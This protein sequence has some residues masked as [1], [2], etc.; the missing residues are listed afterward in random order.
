MMHL[1]KHLGVSSNLCPWHPYSETS[2]LVLGRQRRT[3]A[4]K[5]VHGCCVGW[6]APASALVLLLQPPGHVVGQGL[7]LEGVLMEVLPHCPAASLVMKTQLA[8]Y[9]SV[10]SHGGEG[11]GRGRA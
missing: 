4:V 8:K 9:Q 6:E 10:K 7:L 1:F 2:V 3:K 5:L 11:E